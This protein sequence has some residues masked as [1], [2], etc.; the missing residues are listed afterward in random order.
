MSNA[1]ILRQCILEPRQDIDDDWLS[2]YADVRRYSKDRVVVANDR[3]GIRFFVTTLAIVD[4]ILEGVNDSLA[5]LVLASEGKTKE[6]SRVVAIEES[7]HLGDKLFDSVLDGWKRR[8]IGVEGE[9]ESSLHLQQNI[10][11]ETR[12]DTRP[13]LFK[14]K[15]T[16]VSLPI[17]N[18]QGDYYFGDSSEGFCSLWRTDVSSS[19]LLA[20]W[21]C[22]LVAGVDLKHVVRTIL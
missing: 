1:H 5:T 10:Y 12:S 22:L 6:L 11:V 20:Q 2:K 14:N 4:A 18:W 15:F 13:A 16:R 21:N 17:A 9:D 7:L 3:V 19:K 8:H